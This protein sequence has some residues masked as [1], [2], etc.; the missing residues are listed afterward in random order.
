ME[1]FF[2]AVHGYG[3]GDWERDGMGMHGGRMR[4]C[5]IVELA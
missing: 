1:R 2:E 5:S 3:S 4:R